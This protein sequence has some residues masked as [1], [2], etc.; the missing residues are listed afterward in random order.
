MELR[1]GWRSWIPIGWFASRYNNQLR[2]S[3][4]ND[5]LHLRESGGQVSVHRG[6]QGFPLVPIEDLTRHDWGEI[7]VNFPQALREHLVPR[8]PGIR[9]T[10]GHPQALGLATLIEHFFAT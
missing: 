2:Y 6:S 9:D 7:S 1:N 10:T 8:V 5:T 4:R 3:A